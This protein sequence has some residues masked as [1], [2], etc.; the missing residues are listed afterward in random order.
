MPK[1]T[2]PQHEIEDMVRQRFESVFNFSPI[3]EGLTSQAF[4]FR[5]SS[6]VYVIRINRAIEGFRK[7]LFVSRKFAS[8]ALPIPD[9]IE[10]GYLERGD[11][12]CVSR[13]APGVR[14]ND[15]HA[16][17]IERITGPTMRVME[18]ITSS[19]L[20]GTAGFGRFDAT[21]AAPYATWKE[22]LSNVDDLHRFDW[23]QAINEV[24][25]GVIDQAKRL[26]MA[27]VP[28]C[29]E[30]R[31]LIHGDFGSYNVLA[32]AD[33]ITA[34][35][36]WDLAMFG[37]PLYEVANLFFWSETCLEPHIAHCT[38]QWSGLPHWHERL[39]CYQL[40]IG[41]QEIYE[42]AVGAGAIDVKWLT[43]RCAEIIS[44]HVH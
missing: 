42:S 3:A 28:D 26:V 5:S 38:S 15:L 17:E 40:H 19:N 39:L 25:P 22:Y 36:D 24:D 43:A 33:H 2:V 18:A 41:L 8:P 11:A 29:P 9:V 16:D 6:A 10:V 27:L 14:L 34:V 20:T 7:D 44:Q 30:Y 31:C 1:P 4:T 32:D 21:G 37:D 35:I 13:L 12:Y 23:R